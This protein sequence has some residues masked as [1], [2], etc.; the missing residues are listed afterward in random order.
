MNFWSAVI[1]VIAALVAL[2]ALLALMTAHRQNSLRRFLEEQAQRHPTEPSTADK[3][4]Q[5]KAA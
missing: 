3:A 1:Y 4:Q 5:S 2:Q